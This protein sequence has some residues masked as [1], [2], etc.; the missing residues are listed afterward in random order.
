MSGPTEKISQAEKLSVL[1]NDK[2]VRDEQVHM[3]LAA[4][5]EK[6]H[7]LQQRNQTSTFLDHTHNDTDGGRF[8]AVNKQRVTGSDPAVHVPRQPAGTYWSENF[9]GNEAPFGVDIQSVEPVGNFHEVEQSYQNFGIREGFPLPSD[10]I[11]EEQHVRAERDC[12]SNNS[13]ASANSFGA[14]A[15]T[16]DGVAIPNADA[17]PNSSLGVEPPVAPRKPALGVL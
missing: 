4:L 3:K 6:N 7:K 11:V 8:A 16:G 12:S 5:F 10:A 13:T 17:P 14:D 9:L 1:R 2:L 15:E